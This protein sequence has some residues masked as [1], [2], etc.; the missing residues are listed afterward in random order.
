MR[1]RDAVKKALQERKQRVYDEACGGRTDYGSHGWIEA[2]EWI[3]RGRAIID[4]A[5]SRTPTP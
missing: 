4:R 1:S 5:P 2:L 3:L